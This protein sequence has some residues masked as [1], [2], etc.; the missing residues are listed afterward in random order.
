MSCERTMVFCQTRKQFGLV[1][2][3]FQ[4]S[5]SDDFFVNKTPDRK[6]RMVE[7]FHAGT[8]K[9]VKKHILNNMSQAHGHIQIIACTVAF[10]MG[11]ECKAVHRIIHF[12]PAKNLE[13]YVQK[14]GRAGT[15][16]QPSSCL[17]LHNGL[18][19]AHCMNDIKDHVANSSECTYVHSHFP[20]KFT[21][22][23]SGHQC[24]DICAETC[25]CEQEMCKEPAM[26]VLGATEDGDL[27]SECVHSIV[28]KNKVHLKKELF[29]LATSEYFWW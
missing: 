10:G 5:L 2:S 11:V 18:L 19:G 25:M 17:L 12:G 29:K 15:D 8:P 20:G 23:V 9:S 14:C 21:S 1:Y 4:G 13:C 26:L 7:M 3:V 28:E 22:S 16:G 6:K 27:P 24:C